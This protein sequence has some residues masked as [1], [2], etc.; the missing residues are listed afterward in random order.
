[1]PSTSGGFGRILSGLPAKR[2]VAPPKASLLFEAF[3][4]RRAR[5]T[6]I[7]CGRKVAA[8]DRAHGVLENIPT[9]RSCKS[10]NP[11]LSPGVR[12]GEARRKRLAKAISFRR[13]KILAVFVG[14][15][16]AKTSCPPSFPRYRIHRLIGIGTDGN[17]RFDQFG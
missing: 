1:V 3:T 7:T 10:V 15:S 12:Q 13:T 17:V 5:L 14:A 11:L 8:Q 2:I 9:N 4:Q 16:Q 6:S